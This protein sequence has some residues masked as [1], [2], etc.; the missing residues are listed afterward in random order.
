MEVGVVVLQEDENLSTSRSS[1]TTLGHIP[2]GCFILHQRHLL[3]HPHCCSI[4]YSQKLETTSVSP[5]EE[6]IENMW[7]I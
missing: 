7:Y 4:D 1:Y 6:G 3:D 5:G 2:K